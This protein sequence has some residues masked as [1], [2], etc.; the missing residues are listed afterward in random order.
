MMTDGPKTLFI[1]TGLVYIA[2]VEA[3]VHQVA[4][5]FG[6]D[7]MLTIQL[8]MPPDKDLVRFGK[9]DKVPVAVFYLD[10]WYSATGKVTDIK[11]TYCLLGDGEITGWS[12]TKTAYGDSIILTAIGHIQTMGQMMANFLEGDGSGN[13]SA[14]V[15][16]GGTAQSVTKFKDN[17]FP[18]IMIKRGMFP[19]G[20]EDAL[21]R[22]FDFVENMLFHMKY[23]GYP[24][25]NTSTEEGKVVAVNQDGTLTQALLEA[26]AAANNEDRIA[27]NYYNSFLQN[28]G[29]SVPIQFFVRYNHRTKFDQRWIATPLEQFLDAAEQTEVGILRD[30]TFRHIINHVLDKTIGGSMQ[31][32]FGNTDSY[33]KVLMTFYSFV[34]YK[35]LML[36]TAPYISVA[37]RQNVATGIPTPTFENGP[38]SDK[39]LGAYVSKPEGHF[40]IPPGCNVIAPCMVTNI[41]Y[42]ESYAQQPTRAIAGS[43]Y[44]SHFGVRLGSLG[45]EAIRKYATANGWPIDLKRII[46]GQS[47]LNYQNLLIYPEEF[48]KGPVLQN[49]TMPGWYKFIRETAGQYE[50]KTKLNSQNRNLQN[51]QGSNEVPFSTDNADVTPRAAQLENASPDVRDTTDIYTR[52]TRMK[53]YEARYAP[54]QGSIQMAFNPYIMP[55]YSFVYFDK[56]VAK[57]HLMGHVVN[58]SHSIGAQGGMAT[59][60]QYA[61]GRKLQENYEGAIQEA[62]DTIDANN[63]DPTQPAFDR[64]YAMSPLF[65]TRTMANTLQEET[66]A[67]AYYQRLYYQGAESR[68]YVYK[69]ADYFRTTQ[70]AGFPIPT[71]KAL[72]DDPQASGYDVDLEFRSDV[73]EFLNKYDVAMRRVARPV[74]TL[75]QYIKF[76]NGD[77]DVGFLTSDL[78]PEE[79]YRIKVPR[80]IRIYLASDSQEGIDALERHIKPTVNVDAGDVFDIR[81]DW[82]TRIANYARRVHN[83]EIQQ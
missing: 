65:P 69:F 15:D 49:V 51:A 61:F 24:V 17:L 6:E 10:Q 7:E 31:S 75:H 12:Y 47:K 68:K 41:D 71:S 8:T 54:R 70:L 21:D 5:S 33:L 44:L 23:G 73:G 20:T 55:G 13:L 59:V 77:R 40:A 64:F 34:T 57:M 60:V 66:E 14:T 52:F 36:G 9:E 74:C 29:S 56:G 22:P 28:R 62:L 18:Y 27:A 45:Q 46:E 38:E 53:Y 78:I 11:P 16:S 25:T 50:A 19:T 81:Q 39:R 35:V 82:P 42:N 3:P 80:R 32:L 26:S 63:A 37:N 1:S 4:V 43:P 67:D 48:F 72:P 76:I 2:G 83:R 79:R 30:P 58:V